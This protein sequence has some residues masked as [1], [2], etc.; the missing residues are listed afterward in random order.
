MVKYRKPYITPMISML[1]HRKESAAKM[2]LLIVGSRTIEDFD[3]SS[4]I[5][6]EVDFII[7]GGAKGID[8]LAERYADAHRLSKIIMRPK[9]AKYG[10]AAPLKRNE[11]MVDLA[12][13]ILVICDGKSKGT[14]S[15]ICYAEK[16]NKD[17]CII[18]PLS[19]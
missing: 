14:K 12:D 1:V 19:K 16:K 5:S 7:T 6:E 3:L 8:A 13:R 11:E 2:K 10:K 9:Y 4:Y 18:T 17:I 15:T